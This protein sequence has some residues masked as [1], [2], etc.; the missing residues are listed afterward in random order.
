MNLSTVSD[1]ISSI[2]SLA[3]A[4]LRR[5]AFVALLA[6]GVYPHLAA[7]TGIKA[8]PF[9]IEF[10][11][12]RTWGGGP[13]M[14][15]LAS[16]K[17]ARYKLLHNGRAVGFSS[18]LTNGGKREWFAGDL[19]EAHFL[20]SNG[21]P[22]VLVCTETGTYLVNDQAGKPVVQRLHAF[23]ATRFQFLDSVAG[24]PGDLQQLNAGSSVEAMS[25]DLGKAGTLM[26]LPELNGILDLAT[27]KFQTYAVLKSHQW[28]HNDPDFGG[29]SFDPSPTGQARVWWPSRQQFALVRYTYAGDAKSFALELVDLKTDSAYLVPFD[30]NSTRLTALGDITPAW[31]NHYFQWSGE[32]LTLKKDQKPLP[33]IGS[34]N[35]ASPGNFNYNLKPVGPEMQVALMKF[36]TDHFDASVD[37]SRQMPHV[38][39]LTIQGLPFKLN[40]Y[41]TGK[42]LVLEP[43]FGSPKALTLQI[44]AQF[45]R[46]LAHSKYQSLFTTFGP[47]GFSN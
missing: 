43:E 44:A 23:P 11:S 15:P 26:I 27:L 36:L 45:N 5:L 1:S 46:E 33:W 42:T 19:L 35:A 17:H 41:D 32:K 16:H 22:V 40:Y 21:A 14:N 2:A 7:G 6:V 18:N 47:G 25:R 34:L 3:V 12:E 38:T 39:G 13:S 37:E 24:Q 28:V 29:F 8:G 9:E 4:R 20:Y 10:R 30:L 31:M